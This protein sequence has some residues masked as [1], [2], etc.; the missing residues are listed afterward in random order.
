MKLSNTVD[1]VFIIPMAVPCAINR[2][3]KLLFINKLFVPLQKFS[4][5]MLAEALGGVGGLSR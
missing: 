2:K 3:R 1:S 4:R 5:G